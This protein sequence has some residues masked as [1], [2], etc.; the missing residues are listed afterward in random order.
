MIKK[1]ITLLGQV[2]RFAVN[3][4][5]I[6]STGSEPAEKYAVR[7][8]GLAELIGQLDGIVPPIIYN[9]YKEFM[10][11]FSQFCVNCQNPSFL[12]ENVTDMASSLELF[13]EC[14]GEI[15]A[16]CQ[17]RVKKCIC[18]GEEVIY[19][20]LPDYYGQM[21]EQY[22]G[23][24]NGQ[25]ET[26]NRNEYLCPECHSSDRDRMII[27]FL[28]KINLSMAAEG[29]TKV[30]QIAP[31]AVIEWWILCYCPQVQYEST[32]LFMNGVT[33]RS[34][35]QNMAE[36]ADRSYDLIICS[37]V[38]EHVQD[39]R[40]AL[41]EMK[42]ILK[43]D[44][45]IVFLVPIDLSVDTIDEEWG[46]SEAEN[47]RRFGQGDHCRKYNKAGLMERLEEQFYVHSLGK[48]YFGEEVFRQCGLTDT[49]TLYVLTKEAD[50]DLDMK[51][52][53][54]VDKELCENGPLVSVVMPCYN[55]GRFVAEAI[56]SVL[57]QTYK[58]IEFLVADD[59][60][61]DDSAEV[62]K[63]YSRYFAKE[64][65]FEENTGRRMQSLVQNA[66]GKYV[67]YMHSDDLWEPDKLA[68]QVKYLEEH[69]DCGGC[70]T[71]CVYLDEHME[72]IND[73]IF[74]QQNRLPQEWMRFF[75]EKGNALCNPS[76][77]F[78]REFRL[79]QCKYGFDCYQLPDFFNWIELIQRTSFHI[80]PRILTKMRR[81]SDCVSIESNINCLRT[82][83]ETGNH[84]MWVIK[85][86]EDNFFK[87]VF[88]DLMVRPDAET[89]EEILCEKYF[90][91][92]KHSNMIVQYSALIYLAGIWNEVKS[93]ME[94]KYHYTRNDIKEDII[95]MELAKLI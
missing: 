61:Q 93:C 31:A 40:K 79:H 69:E 7:T 80:V 52:E 73:A 81:H 12:K 76:S 20:P 34:D 26:L 62:M 91:L 95:S 65:Y 5:N 60:S 24:A 15:I 36:V 38:L 83:L 22:G 39:D 63:R 75:W 8:G 59:G 74:I 32:D 90:C 89:R 43:D 82:Y 88:S 25:S 37:H 44:G 57:N 18:C 50:V 72:K 23:I 29:E 27:S 16:G 48:E 3:M 9:D 11:S 54:P 84:W 19:E 4:G 46:C 92:R 71:W 2:K 67:A 70:F 6:L 21:R 56:E 53:M 64:F 55:H 41:S 85:D 42:R 30:L 17:N 14:M 66:T 45:G 10:G 49:S 94:E 33:F 78:R 28:Q 58:N 86:M 1:T 68:L 47:W 51:E 13:I 87:V 77:V 35:I